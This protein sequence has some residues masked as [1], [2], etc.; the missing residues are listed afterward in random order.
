M[1][2][3]DLTKTIIDTLIRN[4]AIATMVIALVALYA[5]LNVTFI[6]WS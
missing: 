6:S 5:H 1:N 2:R 4:F 3:K